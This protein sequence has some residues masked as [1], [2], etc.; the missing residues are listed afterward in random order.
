MK[1]L[2]II[3]LVFS[4]I[5]YSKSG[6]SENKL[7]LHNSNGNLF[8]GQQIGQELAIA[9]NDTFLLNSNLPN[10]TVS[11]N[12]ML[13]DAESFEN[14]FRSV[15]V[16]FPRSG[17]LLFKSNGSFTFENSDN[18]L[19]V[20]TFQ[21]QLSNLLKSES[22]VTAA[23]YIFIGPDTDFDNIINYFDLD[24]DND[25]IL[26]IHEGNRDLDSDGD[27]IPDSFDIDSDN[28]GII[29]IIEWQTE[30]NYIPLSGTDS[31]KN[32]W[33]D[34]FE[35]AMGGTYYNATDTD[36]DGTPDFLDLDTDNDNLSD[37]IECYDHDCNNEV[38]VV[39]LNCDSDSDGLDDAYDTIDGWNNLEN[40]LGSNVILNDNNKNG[41]RDW[42]DV[43][44]NAVIGEEQ[45]LSE[46]NASIQVYPNPSR[47]IFRINTNNDQD[48]V[49]K[50][51]TVFDLLGKQRFYQSNVN[52]QNQI[53]IS[54]LN[55]GIYLLNVKTETQNKTVRIIIQ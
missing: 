3:V 32:G 43:T 18:Y 23:A 16:E 39:A 41:I 14:G 44:Q 35:P 11:G 46:L 10:Q 27:N 51:I 31:N 33:D 50:Q 54:H 48:Q 25:G 30:N 1:P 4:L 49:A 37:N 29:D 53:N 21:Y 5:F 38:D 7:V 28:D 9:F 20:I 47:G 34:A 2:A 22:S 19:G 6:I 8:G 36:N 12:V 52:F 45:F 15:L 24:D 17:K 40:P 13:N 26:D 55:H 42:R